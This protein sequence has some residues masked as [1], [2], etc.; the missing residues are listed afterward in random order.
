MGLQIPTLPSIREA[1]VLGIYGKIWSSLEQGNI[2]FTCRRGQ[3][4]GYLALDFDFET[5]DVVA[6]PRRQVK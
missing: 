2:S 4:R 1:N 3:R 5:H 6:E